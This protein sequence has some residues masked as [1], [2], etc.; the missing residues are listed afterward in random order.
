MSNVTESTVIESPAI[1]SVKPKVAT[2][3]RSSRVS[4]KQVKQI[5]TQ[6]PKRIA[7]L[8]RKKEG[9]ELV[10]TRGHDPEIWVQRAADHQIISAI[11]VLKQDKHNPIDLKDG[12][13]I[14]ADG[15][16][17]EFSHP[18]YQTKEE[19]L[20][21]F[22]TVYTR[23]QEYIG[24]DYRLLAQASHVFPDEQLIVE[25]GIDPWIV[26]CEGSI[27]AYLA[28]IEQNLPYVD[29]LRTGSC[30]CHLGN[31]D[32]QGKHD[33]KLISFKSRHQVVMLLDIF[34][35]L[36]SIVFDKD[37]TSLARRKYYGRSSNCRANP[38]GLEYRVLGNYCMRS[39]ALMELVY[40]LI[41]HTLTHVR[42]NQ[43]Q[44]VLN[45]V[46]F[47]A[48]RAAINT[49]DVNSAAAI[50][51]KVSLPADLMARVKMDRGVLDLNVEWRI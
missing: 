26:G 16:G 23:I 18:P 12:I 33:G 47:E 35:G 19:M 41:S 31:A 32:W 13:K 49:C 39:P 45:L 36:S 9:R 7:D 6:R 28:S 40:D 51:D 8:V 17:L 21:L 4:V 3:Q 10:V 24:P 20:A 43:E 46:D 11:K 50:L 1:Q 38:W 25:H 34:L 48:V 5:V 22:K 27:D 42:A 30:H 44:D 37:D 29:G 15:C 2:R 14:Y